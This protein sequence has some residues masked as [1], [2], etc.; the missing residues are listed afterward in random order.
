LQRYAREPR[1][2]ALEHREVEIEA[3]DLVPAPQML[4]VAAGAAGDVEQRRGAGDALPDDR[5]NPSASPA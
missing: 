2:R 5:M 3:F 4:E 1:A